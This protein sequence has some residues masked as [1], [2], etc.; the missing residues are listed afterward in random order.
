LGELLLYDYEN[1]NLQQ[2]YRSADYIL[3]HREA[4]EDHLFGAAK[5]LFDVRDTI[6]LYDLTNTYFEG[7]A[8]EI[9]K[10]TKPCPR[11]GGGRPVQR[12]AQ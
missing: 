9:P 7:S 3:K 11:E 5:S 8:A 2:I 6:T 12:K 10:A 1:M 4:L